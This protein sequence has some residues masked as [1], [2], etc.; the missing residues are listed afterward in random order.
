MKQH[1][2]AII[3]PKA[4][5]AD[6]VEIGPYTI[7][8]GPVKIDAGTKIMSNV[9]I[10]GHTEIGRDNQV[11]MGAVIG[12]FPQH[13]GYQGEV[14]YTR[15]GDRNIIREYVTIH[16]SWEENGATT[17]GD[18][19]FFMAMSHI[20]HDCHIGNNVIMANGSVLGGHVTIEDRVFISGLAA[21]HQ[22]VRVGKIAMLTGQSSF[23]QDVPPY[24]TTSK[25]RNRLAGVN[26]VGLKRAGFSREVR[27]QIRKAF[28]VVF[29]SGMNAK[30]A[31]KEIE[32]WNPGPEL[33]YFVDF[34]RS[35][36]RGFG[37]F[38]SQSQVKKSSMNNNKTSP[39]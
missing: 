16:R 36:K 38:E 17:I 9:H 10:S 32:S 33:Q 24:C 1:P 26:V 21:L 23:T 4:E 3:D 7:I 18:E 30:N 5:I 29:K 34:L 39:E 2:T 27:D 31:L 25:E 20:A 8:E 35:S 22:F 19:N 11:H 15:I 14:S 28:R 13:L 12:H 37:K 6:D